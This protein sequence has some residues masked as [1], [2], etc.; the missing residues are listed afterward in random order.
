MTDLQFNMD[1]PKSHLFIII[2]IIFLL[3]GGAIGFLVGNYSM[4]ESWKRYNELK[5]EQ[6]ARD[7]I[8]F[9][10]TIETFGGFEYG[11]R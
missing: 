11:D 5:E 7:C 4:N 8:C 3:A 2:A 1:I 6:I 10:K 9:N